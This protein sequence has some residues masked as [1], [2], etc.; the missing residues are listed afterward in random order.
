ML[1]VEPILFRD[2]GASDYNSHTGIILVGGMACSGYWNW[3]CIANIPNA[4]AYYNNK[5]M[6]SADE[7]ENFQELAEFPDLGI[8]QCAIFIDDDTLMVTGGGR[9]DED[10]TNDG[11]WVVNQNLH[12]KCPEVRYIK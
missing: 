11:T 10:T 2:M 1:L 6:L 3:G 8:G 12:K 7:G 5:T 9:P 4:Y